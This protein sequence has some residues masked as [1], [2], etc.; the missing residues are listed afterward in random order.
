MRTFI[1]L[2][3]SSR[4]PTWQNMKPNGTVLLILT[5]LFQLEG[6]SW[7]KNV[8]AGAT[9][10]TWRLKL[11]QLLQLCEALRNERGIPFWLCKLKS[12]EGRVLKLAVIVIAG[13]SSSSGL[14]GYVQFLLVLLAALFVIPLLFVIP[15]VSFMTFFTMK[16]MTDYLIKVASVAVKCR[17]KFHLSFTILLQK[18]AINKLWYWKKVRV[19]FSCT[20]IIQYVNLLGYQSINNKDVDTEVVL[21]TSA[22]FLCDIDGFLLSF[23]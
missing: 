10:S 23:R 16:E 13:M 18:L 15:V 5:K 19:R 12:T 1:V 9:S 22:L 17:N 14:I 11:A 4:K 21:L 3:L 7:R 8:E 6:W 2:K 20:R